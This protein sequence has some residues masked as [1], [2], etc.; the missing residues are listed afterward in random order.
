MVHLVSAEVLESEH[1]ALGTEL[2]GVSFPTSGPPS[3]P[4]LDGPALLG[5]HTLDLRSEE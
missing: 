5:P 2:V 1:V 3:A 4:V